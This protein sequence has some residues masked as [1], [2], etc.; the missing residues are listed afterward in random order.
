[1]QRSL[2]VGALVERQ[3]HSLFQV[4]PVVRADCNSQKSQAADCKHAAE[5]RQRLPA[6][7]THPLGTGGESGVVSE[8]IW[9]VCV[10]GGIGRPSINEEIT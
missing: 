6:A 2:D 7:H 4:Q 5:Q 3:Y 10:G 1:M 8:E 9:G